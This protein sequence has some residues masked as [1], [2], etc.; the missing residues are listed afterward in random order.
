MG[1]AQGY[2]SAQAHDTTRVRDQ[3]QLTTA[4]GATWLV[5]AAVSTLLLGGMLFVI[6][7]VTTVP[8]AAGLLMAVLLMSMVMVRTLVSDR[9]R[10]LVALA[11]LYA[12]ILVTATA[13]T[14]AT[15][16]AP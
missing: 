2:G 6:D 7:G 13:G 5:V 12:T 15:M 11:G 14:V 8:V 4:T 9:R 1:D 10:R 16:I 3:A